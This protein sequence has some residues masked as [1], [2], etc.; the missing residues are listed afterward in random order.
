MCRKYT[1]LGLRNCGLGT[2]AKSCVVGLPEMYGPP[3][4][5]KRKMSDDS[6]SAP[7]LHFTGFTN[8]GKETVL[9]FPNI[10]ICLACGFSRFTTTRRQLNQI[11][12][13]LAP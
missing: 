11:Q 12:A 3:Q 13:G 7:M 4:S 2:G 1:L 8:L 10:L 5:C 9:I 6:W